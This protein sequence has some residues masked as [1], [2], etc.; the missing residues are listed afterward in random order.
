MQKARQQ[1]EDEKLQRQF[2]ENIKIAAQPKNVKREQT[3]YF[4]MRTIKGKA[5]GSLDDSKASNVRRNNY[6]KNANSM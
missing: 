5:K 6:L 1:A 4:M 3:N 2:Y